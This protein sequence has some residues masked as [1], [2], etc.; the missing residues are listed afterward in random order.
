MAHAEIARARS[1]PMVVHV[2]RAHEPA[3]DALRALGPMRGVI[4]SFSGSAELAAEYVRLGWHLGFGGSLT[5]PNARKPAKALI[6]TPRE[7]IVIETDAP[8]Q[9]PTGAEGSRCEPAHL[10]LVAARAAEVLGLSM[11]DL[12]SLTAQNARSLFALE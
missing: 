4:H 10:G 6:A 11:D 9:I 2:L 3:L 1:L 8:D 7:R 12:A 5:R